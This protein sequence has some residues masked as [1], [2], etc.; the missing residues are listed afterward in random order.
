MLSKIKIIPAI[1]II[2]GK[3]VRLEKGVFEKKKIY[4]ENPL[5]IAK[6][7]EDNGFKYLHVVD[8]DG[9][10]NGRLTN[11]EIVK[12]ICQYT[13]LYVDFGGGI[14]SEKDIEDLFSIGVSQVTIG[15]LAIKQPEKV[16]EWIQKFGSDRIIIGA[17]VLK[18]KIA[19]EGWTKS[20]DQN[21]LEFIKYYTNKGAKR[22]V[23]TDVAKDGMMKGPSIDLYQKI[24]KEFPFIELVAS[25]GV[26]CVND[27]DNLNKINCDS[28][29]VGKAFYEGTIK[30]NNFNKK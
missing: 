6:N 27:I 11:L 9:A 16:L 1:D 12:S 18:D 5:K 22:F 4:S 14:Q 29:I 30:L 19:I 10:K 8:L 24:I 28:V 25:G 26:S 20:S 23:C 3:C 2:D 15:S 17:D 7:F 21:I 13:N